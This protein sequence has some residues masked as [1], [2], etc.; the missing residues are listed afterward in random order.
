MGRGAL[1]FWSLLTIFAITAA[2]GFSIYYNVNRV[3]RSIGSNRSDD[4]EIFTANGNLAVVEVRGV[5]DDP[6]ETLRAIRE[7][8]EKTEVKAVVLRISS[9]GGA[10]GPTQEIYDALLRLKKVKKLVCSFGDIAASGGYY[11]AAACDKIVSN[12]GTLTGS[13][14]VIMHFLNLKELYSWAK[15][16]SYIVKAGKYKDIG[17]EARDMTT[18]ER[19]LLQETMDDV[20]GQF[21]DAVATGRNLK[22]DFVDAYA[23]GRIFSGTQAMKLGFVDQLGGE[24]EAIQLAAKLASLGEKPKIIRRNSRRP[25]FRDLFDGK[26]QN[27]GIKG[28]V[29]SFFSEIPAFQIQ[30]GVPYFLPSYML[31]STKGR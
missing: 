23:D 25:K 7:L 16:Q 21:K 3:V 6:D 4:D 29:Q 28:V 26:A 15:V 12:A 27:D 10:V 30:P 9:P 8:E 2:F 13:I 14:G 18:E 1:I 17:S 24:Y 20:H 11:I 22:R 31:N 19:A 5:I